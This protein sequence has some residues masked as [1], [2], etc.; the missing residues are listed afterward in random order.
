LGILQAPKGS[1]V[2][3]VDIVAATDDVATI[4][5]ALAIVVNLLITGKS[6]RNVL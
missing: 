2:V 5:D 6:L 3:P 1:K 4:V